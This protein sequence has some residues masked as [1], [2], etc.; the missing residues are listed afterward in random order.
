MLIRRY[1]QISTTF[2]FNYL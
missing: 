1:T 2:W